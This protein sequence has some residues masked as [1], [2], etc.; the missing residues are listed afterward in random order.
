MPRWLLPALVVLASLAL[1]PVACIARAR[2]I[3]SPRPRVHLIRHMDNQGKFKSQ[4][5]NPLFADGRA[6]RQPVPGTIARGRLG[7]W[8]AAIPVE[9]T[10]R[11]MQR[12]RERFDIYCSPC[13]GLAGNG[14]GIVAAR[15]DLLQEGTWVPPSSL[16][17]PTVVA[18]PD[19][20]LYNTIT[21]G[22]RNMP[23]YGPQINSEDRWA[24]VAYVR[25][26]QRSQSARPEDVPPELRVSLP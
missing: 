14:D 25:A 6:M 3:R 23:R 20:H 22:I 16:H 10:P 7:D 2:G 13:H 17:D 26:L 8:V 18:R 9:V 4:Q 1:V 24:I 15:A 11:L 5:Q 12:G 19:G 21:H